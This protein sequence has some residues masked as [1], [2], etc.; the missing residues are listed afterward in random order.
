MKSEPK[1]LNRRTLIVK[2]RKLMLPYVFL[3]LVGCQLGQPGHSQ[4]IGQSMVAATQAS[5]RPGVM[6]ITPQNAGIAFTGST[7][8]MSQ[9]G[10]FA[11]FR[12]T[13]EMSTNDRQ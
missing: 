9:P 12:G 2:T 13:L 6:P 10:H 3:V 5:G 4:A 1:E 8:L 11:A 7:K